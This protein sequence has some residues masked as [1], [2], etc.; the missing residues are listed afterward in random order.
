MV[1][2]IP[3]SDENHIEQEEKENGWQVNEKVAESSET[4]IGAY[5]VTI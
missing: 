5:T 4:S 2:N 1:N 3:R